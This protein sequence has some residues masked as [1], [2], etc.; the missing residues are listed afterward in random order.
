[1]THSE[2]LDLLTWLQD[3][4][5]LSQRRAVAHDLNNHMTPLSMQVSMLQQ[6]LNKGDLAKAQERV[7]KLD[8]ALRKLQDY[9]KLQFVRFGD[10][11]E[12][13]FCP[14]SHNLESLIQEI[15]DLLKLDRA[16]LEIDFI[17]GIAVLD[18]DLRTLALFLYIGLADAEVVREDQQLD[19]FWGDGASLALHYRASLKSDFPVNLT[20]QMPRY[21][22]LLNATTGGSRVTQNPQRPQHWTLH[23]H[24]Q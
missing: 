14:D 12:I 11:E 23:I 3:F 22:K 18:M 20:L 13:P 8:A 10:L 4:Q 21:A 1:M 19:V 16:Q 15:C 2:P 24:N 9:T 6:H 7:Q 17:P 5:V